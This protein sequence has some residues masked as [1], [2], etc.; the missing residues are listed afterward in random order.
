MFQHQLGVGKES[1]YRIKENMLAL[2]F[3]LGVRGAQE[4]VA[5][6]LEQRQS[7][8]LSPESSLP[9]SWPSSHPPTLWSI[10]SG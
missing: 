1:R 6:V 7:A 9:P 2:Q 8:L 10:P 4:T 5:V 3:R